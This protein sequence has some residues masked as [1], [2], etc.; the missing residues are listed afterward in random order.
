MDASLRDLNVLTVCDD[1]NL[2]LLLREVLRSMNI[3]RVLQARDGKEALQLLKSETAHIVFCD[4][5]LGDMPGLDLAVRL[6][7][8]AP[9]TPF[10]I[11]SASADRKYVQLAAQAGV[12]G[13]LLKPFSRAQIEA[14]LR[15][16]ANSAPQ[17]PRPQAAYAPRPAPA[18][19]AVA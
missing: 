10:M 13:Y 18:V 8:E 6:R 5:Q 17:K 16:V 12:Q 3:G 2:R 19:A 4:W 11:M 9:N 15:L 7:L 1:A 14:K